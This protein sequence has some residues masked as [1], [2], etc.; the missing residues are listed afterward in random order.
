MGHEVLLNIVLFMF[1]DNL[2]YVTFKKHI[3]AHS[4]HD[5]PCFN[6]PALMQCFH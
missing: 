3:E 5:V 1:P 6:A 2:R 4:R